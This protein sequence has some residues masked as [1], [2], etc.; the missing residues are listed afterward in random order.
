MM[1]CF[2]ETHRSLLEKIRQKPLRVT[3]LAEGYPVSLN[4]ISKHI[5]FLEKA[6]L[7]KRNIEGRVHLCEANPDELKNA[8]KWIKKYTNFWNSK[9]DNLE[10]YVFNKKE[11]K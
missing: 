6:G 2:D 3:T 7:I 8:E 1:N 5:K 4:A 9:L 10:T 11:R